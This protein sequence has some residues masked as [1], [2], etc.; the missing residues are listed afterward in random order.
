MSKKRIID[1]KKSAIEDYLLV[2]RAIKQALPMLS[3][4]ADEIDNYITNNSGMKGKK[5]LDTMFRKYGKGMKYRE[6]VHARLIATSLKKEEIHADLR[7]IVERISQE[8]T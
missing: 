2:A 7:D 5:M 3:A 8:S 1:L 4:S 6:T